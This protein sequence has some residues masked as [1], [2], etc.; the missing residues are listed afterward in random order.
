MLSPTNQTALTSASRAGVEI[1]IVQLTKEELL[2]A[3]AGFARQK[4]QV[5]PDCKRGIAGL[6][7][8]RA[9]YS[10]QVEFNDLPEELEKFLQEEGLLSQ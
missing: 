6:V 2:Q 9:D 3:A 1:V 8:L 10:A 4:G 5:R 7:I